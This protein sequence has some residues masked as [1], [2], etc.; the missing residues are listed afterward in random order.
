M[1]V[2][3]QSILKNNAQLAIWEISETVEELSSQLSLETLS[4]EKFCRI[5][6][7][8][9]KKEWLAARALL[10]NILEEEKTVSYYPSGKPFFADN[11]F[12]ISISHTK[13]QVAVLLH[14]TQETGIDIEYI[15]D[16][17]F[18]LKERFL[19]TEE[20]FFLDKKNEELTALLCWSAKETMFKVMDD[21]GIDFS[22]QFRIQPFELSTQGTLSAKETKTQKQQ[23]FD[24]QYQVFD[25]FVLTYTI[26]DQA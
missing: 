13:N 22:E 3:Q 23:V 20:L 19:H 1:P 6:T 25:N 9:R 7:E 4:D 15:S 24:I 11:T 10:K 17:A 21:A 14:P 18:R 26:L 2:F 8:N 5:T 12:K 16:R